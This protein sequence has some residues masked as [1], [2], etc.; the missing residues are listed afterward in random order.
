[1]NAVGKSKS[2]DSVYFSTSA[3]KTINTCSGTLVV[4]ESIQVK[5]LFYLSFEVI[6]F[7]LNEFL[8]YLCDVG[9]KRY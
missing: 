2:L 5:K 8:G 9:E 1:M 4:D 6:E 3:W 7:Y